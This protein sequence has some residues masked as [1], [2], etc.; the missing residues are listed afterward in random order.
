MNF[1]ISLK[2][3]WS[4]SFPILC[5]NEILKCPWPYWVH[6]NQCDSLQKSWCKKILYNGS[7]RLLIKGRTVLVPW[8]MMNW[9]SLIISAGHSKP[10]WK[11][12]IL[13]LEQGP[14]G[15]GFEMC[16]FVLS[17]FIP[18][19][20][21]LSKEILCEKPRNWGISEPIH[22]WQLLLRVMFVEFFLFHKPKLSFLKI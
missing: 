10:R 4:K 20:R 3:V 8:D 18:Q 1:S 9:F 15:T 11:E 14:V 6:P 21:F 16:K 5:V 17:T 12:Q 22:Q 13:M 7:P 2:E 19:I